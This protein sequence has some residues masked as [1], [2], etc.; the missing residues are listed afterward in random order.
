[1]AIKKA[2]YKQ[3]R[4]RRN[5]DNERRGTTYTGLTEEQAREFDLLDIDDDSERVQELEAENERLKSERD[6]AI[7]TLN[8]GGVVVIGRCELTPTGLLFPSDLTIE[9]WSDIGQTLRRLDTSLQWM[10]GDWANWFVESQNPKDDNER[11]V[12]Y[13]NLAEEFDMKKRTIQD[14]AY[15]SRG[16][17]V[18]ERSET[19][20][21]GHHRIVAS[22]HRDEQMEWLQKAEANNWSVAQLRNEIKGDS[23]NR[24]A[25][26]WFA[27]WQKKADAI[28][29]RRTKAELMQMISYYQRLLDTKE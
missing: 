25:N 22:L 29:K 1:M 18:S 27:R 11:G 20:S 14:Y 10:L 5:Q 6:K 2:D 16:V 7:Q 9:E 15:V 3:N 13:D 23:Q 8:S 28:A 12:L 24:T 19:L 26:D 21:F 17:G 4:E